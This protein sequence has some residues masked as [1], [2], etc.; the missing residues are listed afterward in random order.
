MLWIA[1]L[2]QYCKI[3]NSLLQYFKMN[4]IV[5][6]VLFINNLCFKNK[7]I[8]KINRVKQHILHTSQRPVEKPDWL[9]ACGRF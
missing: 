8:C 5:V 7:T 9:P 2:T 1:A 4:C 6:I 3:L